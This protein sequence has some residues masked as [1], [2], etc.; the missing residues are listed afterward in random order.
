[1]HFVVIGLSHKTAPIEIREKLAVPQEQVSSLLT[2]LLEDEDIQ[3]GML[4]STCN[5]VEAYLVAKHPQRAA[6]A[7]RKLFSEIGK[8][9]EGEMG[10]YLYVKDEEEAVA[11]LFRVTA[12]LD[13]MI[14]GEPQIGGQVKEAYTEA[15]ASRAT[16][17]YLNKLIHKALNVAKRIRTET[18]I[19]Q[20]PVSIGYAAVLLA[21][22]IF[23][24]LAENRVLLLGAGEIGTL[25]ARHLAERH[26][27]EIWISNRTTEKAEE[28]AQ[29]LDAKMISYD[30]LFEKL[31]DV[32]IVIA[33][34]AAGEYVIREQEV[35][36]A[37][38][39]RGNKPM[40]FIDIAVPRN[41]E[42]SV[43]QIENVYL[44]DID[45]LKG[46]VESNLKER[47]REAKKGE[48]IISH[49]VRAFL[50]YVRQMDLSPTILQLSKKFDLIRKLELEKY[51]ARHPHVKNS[52]RE[53]LEAFSKAMVNK[54]LHEPIILMK[55]EEAKD[56][57]PKYSE[58]LKKLFRLE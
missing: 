51:L 25:A 28:I 49:E 9:G 57:A 27:R 53:A 54:I 44:Y 52:D 4:V 1:M 35:R 33:S 6:E 55:T 24:D 20:H 7:A 11:H 19:G 39:R 48:G 45:H 37:M 22:K 47:E 46:I 8:I 18:G 50:S 29:D 42:P 36:E 38:R 26:V 2:K 21:E 13:S 3:E 12:S 43:N 23:G 58:I 40:F 16:G 14:V 56:G 17:T 10:R 5:R 34:T 32:D 41:I 30:R 31:S 15:V